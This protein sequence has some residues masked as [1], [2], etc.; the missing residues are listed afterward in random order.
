MSA[1]QD[2]ADHDLAV[3]GAGPAGL[4]AATCAA[5]LGLDVVLLDEHAAPGGR[6]YRNV[7]G[8]AEAGPDDLELL[9]AGTRE[10][11]ALAASFRASGA[12][13]RPETAVWMIE[14]DGGSGASLGLRDAAGVKLLSA[15]RAI[16]AAGAMERAVPIP[17][18]TL[19]GVMT[20]GAAQTLLKASALVP[21]TP[22]VIAGSGPLALLY[23]AQLLAIGGAI[24]AILDTA[25]PGNRIKALPRLP[26]LIGQ[27]GALRQGLGWQRTIK[28]AGVPVFE[29]AR[30]LRATGN[31]RVEAVEFLSGRRRRRI[32]T[33]L[34]LLHEGLVPD[35]H[36][37]MSAGCAMAWDEV[38]WYWRT[39]TDHW[40]ASSVETIAVVGDCAGI[41]GAEAAAHGGRLAALDAARRLGALDTTARE[42]LA[43]PERRAL[44]RLSG[45]RR[46]LEA[47]YRPRPEI[48]TPEDPA[49]LVCRCEE[50][51]VA[52]LRRAAALGCQ[53]PNQA[54][55]FTRC[56]MGAC[57]G[58]LCGLTAAAVIAR[59]RGG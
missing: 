21:E 55:A 57:Q 31:G 10:G 30:E 38:G 53:G 16:V 25:P 35:H 32:A 29:G 13:Y 50:V 36:L 23:A 34:L 4:A 9:G 28:A 43:A 46:F 11:L 47:L 6:V 14:A 20:V 33:R 24:A 51:S 45:P 37:A 5:G 1:V 19:P 49:V 52:A 22:P 59:A 12:H 41:G 42:R 26:G 58:R 18:W 56:G 17:G 27:L 15:R 40:G 54:K 48:L 2:R 7:E 44:A 3:V 39:L 8:L